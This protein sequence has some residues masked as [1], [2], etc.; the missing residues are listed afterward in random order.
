MKYLKWI[1]GRRYVIIDLAKIIKKSIWKRQGKKSI[2][3][4]K[5]IRIMTQTKKK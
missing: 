1:R 2:K 3:E 5:K 4:N